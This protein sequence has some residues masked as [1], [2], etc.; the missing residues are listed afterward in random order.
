MRTRPAIVVATLVLGLSA[1][2]W[3]D[4]PSIGGCANGRCPIR[5]SLNTLSEA[6][7]ASMGNFYENSRT[8]IGEAPAVTGGSG[9]ATCSQ[10]R[11]TTTSAPSVRP[12]TPDVP[13]PKE[14]TEEKK[15]GGGIGGFLNKHKWQ[16]GGALA[17]GI[18]SLLLG[19]GIF[20]LLAGLVIS[21]AVAFVG[22]KLFGGK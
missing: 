5:G 18:A 3:A 14:V 19:G 21:V 7:P 1:R 8:T 6:P 9:C 13:A 15:D 12:Q 20:G 16:I 17:G 10:A 2:A 4:P 11:V 22:P